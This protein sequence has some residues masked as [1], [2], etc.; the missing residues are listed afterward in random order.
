MPTNQELQ[1]RIDELLLEMERMGDDAAQGQALREEVIALR[2]ELAQSEESCRHLQGMVNSL[3]A[4][5]Q[6]LKEI[7]EEKQELLLARVSA[8]AR[9]MA[10]AGARWTEEK[11]GL[12]A[13]ARKQDAQI[14]AL[15][16]RNSTLEYRLADREERLDALM[17]G[18]GR[19]DALVKSQQ[20]EIGSLRNELSRANTLARKLQ[21]T[22][23]RTFWAELMDGIVEHRGCAITLTLG[24]AFLLWL[25]YLL[26]S[27]MW[28]STPPPAPGLGT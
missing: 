20:A 16:G 26:L 22:P 9:Q 28:S 1:D 23:P 13:A 7:Y 21:E 15:T 24:L 10:E 6:S 2:G 3:T 11:K 17:T 5:Q 12:E 4:G 25:A 19:V 8:A 18:Q 14:T 27:W